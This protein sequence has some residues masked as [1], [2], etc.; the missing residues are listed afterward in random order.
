M[1]PEQMC[2]ELDRAYVALEQIENLQAEDP[3]ADHS[4]QM[5]R[6]AHNALKMLDA[7]G[8]PEEIKRNV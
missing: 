7:N 8:V 4:N 6:I 3:E 1:T 2:E 5:F